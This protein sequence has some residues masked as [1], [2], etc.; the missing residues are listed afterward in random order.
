MA[1]EGVV[2]VV[3][4]AGAVVVWMMV[5]AEERAVVAVAV[6]VAMV[7]LAEAVVMVVV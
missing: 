5:D 6:V 4:L 3:G 7:A 1:V 2:V